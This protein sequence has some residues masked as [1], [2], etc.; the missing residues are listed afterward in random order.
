MKAVIYAFPK[1]SAPVANANNV[2]DVSDTLS[3]LPMR[4]QRWDCLYTIQTSHTSRL[5]LKKGTYLRMDNSTAKPSTY[6]VYL[7]TNSVKLIQITVNFT[8]RM[9][10]RNNATHFTK[11]L[12]KIALVQGFFKF[13]K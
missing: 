13:R 1:L 10:D 5:S 12:I 11:C 7:L 4:G 6:Q 8:C 3:Y 2:K 9:I